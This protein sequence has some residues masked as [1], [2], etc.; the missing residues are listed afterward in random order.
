MYKSTSYPDIPPSSPNCA[1]GYFGY[2]DAC[3]QLMDMAMTRPEAAKKCLQ[4]G[5]E[6][7]CCFK[8]INNNNYNLFPT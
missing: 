3:Y 8:R 6:I 1:P 4:E 2:G 5:D 7:F